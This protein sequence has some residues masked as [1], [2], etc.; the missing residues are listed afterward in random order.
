MAAVTALLATTGGE[1]KAADKA[2]H[3]N[4]GVTTINV[5]SLKIL[6]NF[7][8]I[9]LKNIITQKCIVLCLA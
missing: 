3:E 1:I 6:L 7:M 8:C 5:E 2:A 9:Y 4:A